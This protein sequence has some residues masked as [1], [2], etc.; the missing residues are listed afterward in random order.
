MTD[1]SSET[2]SKSSAELD[3]YHTEHLVVRKSDGK[4][5]DIREADGITTDEDGNPVVKM[6]SL[7]KGSWARKRDLG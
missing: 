2:S 7:Q 3:G 1:S 5:M 6:E 4:E